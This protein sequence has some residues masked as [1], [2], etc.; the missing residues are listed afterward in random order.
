MSESNPNLELYNKVR[1]VPDEAKKTIKGGRLKGMTDIN[2][3]WRIKKLTE[4]FGPCGMGWYYKTVDKRLEQAG[5]EIAAFVDIELY[6][7]IK[8]VWSMP[9]F[10]SGGSKFVTDEKSG[11]FVSDECYKMATTDALSVACK[12]L[13]IGA[14]VYFQADTTKYDAKSEANTEPKIDSRQLVELRK[15]IERT[16]KNEMS[17]LF[18]YSPKNLENMTVSQFNDAMSLLKK[19]PDY[20]SVEVPE[21]INEEVP[22]K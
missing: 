20:E 7:K 8:G 11:L 1:A 9:I 19:I 12:Q 22:F 14:D 15:E 21:D 13:G 6:I 5:K 2:P 16:G 17:I 4:E 18:R 10:G 3:M